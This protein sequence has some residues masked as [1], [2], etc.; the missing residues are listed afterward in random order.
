VGQLR[1]DLEAAIIEVRRLGAGALD[2]F[3]ESLFQ[4]IRW[5]EV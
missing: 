5:R 2:Q 4:P 1:R 3:S